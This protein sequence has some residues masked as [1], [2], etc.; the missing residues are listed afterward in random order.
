[1]NMCVTWKTFSLVCLHNFWLKLFTRF[2]DYCFKTFSWTLLT[3]V[4][5][6]FPKWPIRT[7]LNMFMKPF[8]NGF[9]HLI[10]NNGNFGYFSPLVVDIWLRMF[11][12][13]LISN[14]N[15]WLKVFVRPFNNHLGYLKVFLLPFHISRY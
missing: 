3:I 9:G 5:K 8:I 14:F 2:L 11:A 1:M 7:W 12:W 6:T 10:F 13:T 4:H 15:M